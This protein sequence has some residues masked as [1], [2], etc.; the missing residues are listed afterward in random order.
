MRTV[1]KGTIGLGSFA[2]PVKAYSATSEPGSG[3][4]QVHTTDGG[5]LRYRRVCEVDGAEVPAEEIGKGYQ[6][7]GGD[8]VVLSEEELAS[9]S[10]AAAES[11]RIHGFVRGEH[12]DP[13]LHAKSY[14]L[15]PEVSANKPYVLLCEALRLA[16]RVAV[17]KVALR[18]RE[19]LG[20]LRVA[21]QVL[22]LQTLHWPQAVR[23]ADFPFLHE[24][25]DLRMAQV[26]AAANLIENLSGDFEPH[27]F[28]D[29]Y[30]EALS[31]LVEAR[32]EGADVAR[33]TEPAQE[34][35]VVELLATLR[36]HAQQR[37]DTDQLAARR[38]A[39]SRAEAAAG[40]AKQAERKARKAASKA[41][42]A[43]KGSH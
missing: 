13:L 2:I 9:L 30:S 32:L 21:D 37:T 38:T 33:P 34:E 35:G 7:A 11:I 43:P 23:G 8:V 15:E 27:R 29:G 25:V 24:D 14:Y 5:R 31:A 16:D 26:R 12:I 20:V 1:W 4:I 41:R 18:Q 17:V 36:E 19:T 6:S 10:G 42:A 40:E 3:L 22:V 39:V 28:T